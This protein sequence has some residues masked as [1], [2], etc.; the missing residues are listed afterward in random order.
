MEQNEINDDSVSSDSWIIEPNVDYYR[1]NHGNKND[2]DSNIAIDSITNINQ[3][4]NGVRIVTYI[5]NE[6]YCLFC[7]PNGLIRLIHIDNN[8]YKRVVKFNY[9]QSQY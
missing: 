3:D 9:Q 5:E 7:A 6:K 1:I 4:Y 2:D 8:K